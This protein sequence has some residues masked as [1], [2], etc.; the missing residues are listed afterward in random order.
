MRSLIGSVIVG[1]SSGRPQLSTET[2]QLSLTLCSGHMVEPKDNTRE[3]MTS[4]SITFVDRF[5]RLI[6]TAVLSA[7]AAGAATLA[8]SPGAEAN[9]HHQHHHH[10]HSN[11]HHEL[12]R[13]RREFRHDGRDL[14]HYRRAINHDWRHLRGFDH[15]GVYGD[16]PVIAPYGYGYHRQI[17]PGFGI[18]IRF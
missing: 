14:H 4:Q 10:H 17:Q 18:Q 8:L 16:P 15:R 11:H 5:K 9:Q 13:I 12:R 3:V 1:T 7:A 6:A 2:S